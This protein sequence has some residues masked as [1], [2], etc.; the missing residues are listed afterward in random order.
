M[1]GFTW[2]NFLSLCALAIAGSI[3]SVAARRIYAVIKKTERVI[4]KTVD[5]KNALS[6]EL[7]LQRREETQLKQSIEEADAAIA[8]MTRQHEQVEARMV[9]L[10]DQPR[11]TLTMVDNSWR[12]FDRL[13][14]AHVTNPTIPNALP[15]NAGGGSWG[16]GRLIHGYGRSPDEVRTRIEAR[17]SPA[18]GFIV[19]EIRMLN[20]NEDVPPADASRKE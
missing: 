17:Y 4:S 20:L 8:L 9:T 15:R 6:N 11:R 10:K 5:E 1:M 13:F 19:G 7:R 16:E 3:L 14:E 2:L 18:S 12:R